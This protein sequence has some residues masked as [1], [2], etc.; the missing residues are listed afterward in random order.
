MKG[1]GSISLTFDATN[2]FIKSINGIRVVQIR[3]QSNE[4]LLQ[5]WT[6]EGK[7]LKYSFQIPEEV[8]SESKTVVL[9]VEDTCGD[10]LKKVLSF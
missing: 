9:V 2:N 7:V 8:L 3:E 6:F 4:L 5:D 1:K 10:I